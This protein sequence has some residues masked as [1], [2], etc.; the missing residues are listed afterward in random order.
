MGVTDRP[1]VENQMARGLFPRFV[2]AIRSA[3]RTSLPEIEDVHQTFSPLMP[4]ASTFHVAL[5]DVAPGVAPYLFLVFQHHSKPWA[6]GR[7]TINLAAAATLG[8]PGRDNRKP[9]LFERGEEGFYRIGGVLQ[10]KDMWWSL[11]AEKLDDNRPVDTAARSP[12]AV[13]RRDRCANDVVDACVHCMATIVV[14][15]RGDGV[16]RGDRRRDSGRAR[17]DWRGRCAACGFVRRGRVG[18]FG[19]LIVAAT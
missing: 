14:L 10:R 5:S 1:F 12:S 2:R 16:Q 4:K 8:A 3:W 13:D 11:A 18:G 15:G 19:I 7:F 9:S 6:A 17:R